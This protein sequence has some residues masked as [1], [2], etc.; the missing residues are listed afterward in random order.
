[1]PRDKTADEVREE[2]KEKIKLFVSELKN[3]QVALNELGDI[4]RS[5]HLHNLRRVLS[6]SYVV[7]SLKEEFVTKDQ[8][9]LFPVSLD[10]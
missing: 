9:V 10:R 3:A 7:L 1:M 6:Q 4:H 8:E 5:E 2:T